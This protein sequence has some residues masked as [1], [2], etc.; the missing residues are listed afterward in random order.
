[1]AQLAA[2]L[3]RRVRIEQPVYTPD[4]A[5]GQS[6]GWQELATVWA[7]V[8]PVSGQT[9]FEAAQRQERVTHKV[10]IR[11]REDVTASMRLVLGSRVFAIRAVLD[12][13]EDRQRL[14]LLVEEGAAA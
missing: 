14:L 12:P 13:E 3:R 7:D 6:T 4:D 11:F 9:V 10:F 2:T 5:G 8:R 1:M